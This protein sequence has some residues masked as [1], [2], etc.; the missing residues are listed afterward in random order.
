MVLTEGLSDGERRF[1]PEAAI[2][3]G[4]A[5]ERKRTWRSFRDD[6]RAGQIGPKPAIPGPFPTKG[7]PQSAPSPTRGSAKDVRL[8]SPGI[9]PSR[10]PPSVRQKKTM[11]DATPANV[12]AACKPL[13]NGRSKLNPSAS[14]AKQTTPLITTGQ[15]TGTSDSPH[16]LAQPLERFLSFSNSLIARPSA[17]RR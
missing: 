16:T 11:A 13:P 10:Y 7:M 1:R 5:A 4:S 6:W 12:H 3:V 14:I 2:P 9:L 15:L 8:F 17:G